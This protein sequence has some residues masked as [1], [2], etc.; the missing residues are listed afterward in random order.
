[1][2]QDDESFHRIAVHAA[3]ALGVAIGRIERVERVK[4]GLTN[5]SWLASGAG[6]QVVVRISTADEAALQIDRRSEGIVLA[7]VQRA[8]LGPDV[9]AWNPGERLLVTRFIPGKVWT[10]EDAREPD[11]LRR[12]ALLLRQLHSLPVRDDIAVIDLA[13]ILDR[14][15]TTLAE[16]EQPDPVSRLSRADMKRAASTLAAT[17][18]PCLCHNDAHHLNVIDAGALRLIDWEY[19]GRGSAWF[20]LASV[21][22]NHDFDDVRRRQLLRHYLGKDSE[23]AASRLDLACHLFEA[24]REL[25]LAV[26][27]A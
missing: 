17:G 27:A 13:A 3:D 5:E 19:A 26:R 14:Y 25:W 9:L 1:M 2:T 11:N 4:G 20:D 7:E 22:C 8:G 15:W 6:E 24:I 16:R 23:T 21:A 18:P 12:L 10:R